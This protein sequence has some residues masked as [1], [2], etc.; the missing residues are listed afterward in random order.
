MVIL[1]LIAF[2]QT[3]NIWRD[4]HRSAEKGFMGT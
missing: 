3:I 4:V 2:E 1:K